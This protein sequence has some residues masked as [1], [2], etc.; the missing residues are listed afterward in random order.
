MQGHLAHCL[1]Q[2]LVKL[3]ERKEGRELKAGA[4]DI[5]SL[6]L[7][8]HFSPFYTLPSFRRQIWTHHRSSLAWASSRKAVGRGAWKVVWGEDVRASLPWPSLGL[9]VLLPQSSLFLPRQ[10]P[11]YTLSWVLVPAISPYLFGAGWWCAVMIYNST[12]IYFVSVSFL[13]QSF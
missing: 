6:P 8:S 4:P 3:S 2:K 5:F 9:L 11:P 1:I 10:L 7:Q 13:A 12:C